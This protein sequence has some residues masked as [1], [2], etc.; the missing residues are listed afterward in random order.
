MLAIYTPFVT[1][2]NVSF[3]TEPPTLEG[4]AQRLRSGI[5]THPWIVAATVGNIAGYAYAGPHME[6]A[7]YRWWVPLPFSGSPLRPP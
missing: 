2:T 7:A 1:N 6:R 3:E 5:Q 4:M